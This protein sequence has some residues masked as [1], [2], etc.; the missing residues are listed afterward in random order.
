[1]GYKQQ[2]TRPGLDGSA[3]FLVRR[4]GQPHRTTMPSW[5]HETQFRVFPRPKPD[6][7]FFPIRAST[8]DDDFGEAV[9]A[10]QVVKRLGVQEQ[11]TYPVR[12]PGL[13]GDPPT[14][15][16]AQ[17]LLALIKD[18]KKE[19]FQR[20]FGDWL[21]WPEGGKGRSA[22]LSKPQDAIFWQ[23]ATIMARGKVFQNKAGQPA[24][25]F[26]SLLMGT[27]SL[28]MGFEKIGNARIVDQAGNPTYN[29]PAPESIG[30]DGEDA[31]RQRDA[32]YAA[33]YQLGDWCSIEHGRVMRIYQAP[34]STD[35]FD[36]PHYAIVPGDEFSLTGAEELVRK[37][38][39]P[40]ED[41]IW[42]HSAEE[43]VQLLCRAF[44]PEAVDY[45]LNGS[46]YTDLLP[47]NVKN[48]W[49]N[50]QTPAASWPGYGPGQAQ[51][52]QAQQMQWPQG[53]PAAA[54]QLQPGV[55]AA[56][57]PQA[58]APAPQPA[59]APALVPQ[60]L[61]TPPAAAPQ[62]QPSA[63]MTLTPSAPNPGTAAPAPQPTSTAA[64][65]TGP[66]SITNVASAAVAA[67]APMLNGMDMSGQGEAP[68]E[69]D[70]SLAEAGGFNNVAE[71]QQPVASPQTLQ[72]QAQPQ[73]PAPGTATPAGAAPVV[74]NDKLQAA[75]AQLRSQRQGGNPAG[76]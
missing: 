43:Q 70:T 57:Q 44:P 4:P 1:M 63:P 11:F 12:I 37:N 54:P 5:D 35:G 22:R 23:G 45:A 15:I 8:D 52:P 32:I 53:Q 13:Q 64:P 66:V 47:A 2:V 61:P 71:L 49:R 38:W 31:R 59:A 33:M 39:V 76:Q 51:A 25:Q 62:P 7:G 36:K 26:P 75:V 56:P 69:V 30:G 58:S 19:L 28:R 34:P 68:D 3:G 46:P 67:A 27:V 14:T 50:Q 40:W 21:D 24:P 65:G 60:G 10:E 72:P 17:A 41:L 55:P 16:L 6:G 73:A 48:A 9:W 18:K 29:G 42:Y 20:G 74:P